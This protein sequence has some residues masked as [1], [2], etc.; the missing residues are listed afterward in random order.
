[1]GY[2]LG[3]FPSFLAVGVLLPGPVFFAVVDVPEVRVVPGPFVPLLVV[4]LVRGGFVLGLPVAAVGVP[5]VGFFASGAFVFPLTGEVTA[6]LAVVGGLTGG[7]VVGFF[8][9]FALL[10]RT[11]GLF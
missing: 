7:L 11:T 3:L 10:M 4:P 2:S 1:M 6:V 5:P 9:D 8:D